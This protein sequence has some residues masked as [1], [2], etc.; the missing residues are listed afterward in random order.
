MIK[1]FL[2]CIALWVTIAQAQDPHFSQ[3]YEAPLLL[4]PA[5]AGFINGTFQLNGIYRSQWKE[6]TI[7][8][9]TIAGTAN[10][11]IPAGKNKNNIIGIA[12]TDFADKS[13]DAA[14]TTNHFDMAFA[15]HRNF[16]SNFNHYAGGGLMFGY[17]S[18]T[19]DMSAL[20]FDENFNGG[21]NTEIIGSTKSN[22]F[23]VSAGGEY[24][25]L[26][27]NHQINAGMAC[28]HMTNPKV[29]Y[30]NNAES[31]IYRKWVLNGGYSRPLSPI[32]DIMPRAALFIQGPSKEFI[33]GADAKY[34]LTQNA[35]TNYSV[36]AGIYYRV[37]DAFIPKVRVDMGDLSFGLSYDFTA[38]K[39]SKVNTAAGGPELTV[40]YVGRVK[41]IS[42]G[43]IYNPRF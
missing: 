28:Y 34:K 9:K 19:F 16:G 37:G 13:G 30:S 15:Y 42:A 26:D 1:L 21:T 10:V 20:T 41:G 35:T 23:D 14:Y 2:L 32:L 4:N 43:R 29:S 12:V 24:N 22:Y 18:T 36:Y 38:S 5:R 3:F 40:V 27:D 7:P 17:S 8:F 25:F 33:L 11:N 39:L 31:T 6:I